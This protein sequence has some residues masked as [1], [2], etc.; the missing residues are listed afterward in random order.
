M[1]VLLW[2]PRS[3]YDGFRQRCADL[4]QWRSLQLELAEGDVP[5]DPALEQRRRYLAE[6]LERAGT[7]A[8][9]LD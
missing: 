9:L 1:L 5:I 8:A 4:F 6:L 2:V 7:R 3:G